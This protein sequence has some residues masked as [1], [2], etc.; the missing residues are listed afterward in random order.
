MPGSTRKAKKA[1]TAKSAA[2]ATRKL[3]PIQQTQLLRS[4]MRHRGIG[5]RVMARQQFMRS[6]DAQ[7]HRMAQHKAITAEE[8]R[9]AKEAAKE[10]ARQAVMDEERVLRRSLRLATQS[11]VVKNGKV[12]LAKNKD[13]SKK[14]YLYPSILNGADTKKNIKKVDDAW[15]TRIAKILRTTRRR[16]AASAPPAVARNNS[17]LNKLANQLSRIHT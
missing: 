7:L 2:G 9:A 4:M 17:E 10:A 13:P 1:S 8:R 16:T 14:S 6:L 12:V 15:K 11:A 3:S 5:A